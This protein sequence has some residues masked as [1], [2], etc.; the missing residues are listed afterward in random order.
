[1]SSLH[2]VGLDDDDPEL[3]PVGLVIEIAYRPEAGLVR[4]RVGNGRPVILS[5]FGAPLRLRPWAF[6]M[7]PE[8]RIKFEQPYIEYDAEYKKTVACEN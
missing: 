5:G 3:D 4:F 6:L 8:D 2:D 7:F 1:M